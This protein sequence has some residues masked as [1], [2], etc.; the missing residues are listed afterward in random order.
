MADEG[1]KKQPVAMVPH[2]PTPWDLSVLQVVHRMSDRIVLAPVYVNGEPKLALAL[3]CQSPDGGVFI[4][5]LAILVQPTDVV[6]DSRGAPG[7]NKTP[8]DQ[9]NLN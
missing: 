1:D 4:Q 6:L 3:L 2:A 9:K 7:Y 5:V 8:P